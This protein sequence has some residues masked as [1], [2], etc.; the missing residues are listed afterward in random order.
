MNYILVYN[1]ENYRQAGQTIRTKDGLK[2]H[3]S[4]AI[5]DT[6]LLALYTLS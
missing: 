6:L 2:R 4:M 1:E 3:K 5:G